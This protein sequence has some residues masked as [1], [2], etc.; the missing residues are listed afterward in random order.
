VSVSND[1][2]ATSLS[3]GIY[4]IIVTDVN[5]CVESSSITLSS[6]SLIY[7]NINID[8]V[9]CNGYSDGA[10]S[11][12]PS[13]GIPPYTFLWSG[14]TSPLTSSTISGLNAN[15][16]YYVSITDSN[17]CSISG[18]PVD[19]PEPPAMSVNFTAHD[20]NGYN[21]SCY[22][23][24]NAIVTSNINGGIPPYTYSEDNVS[25]SSDSIS[26]SNPSGWYIIYVKDANSC[27][28]TDSVNLTI[29]TPIYPNIS[30]FDSLTCNGSIDGSAVVNPSGGSGVYNIIWFE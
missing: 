8:T 17:G 7:P 2:I 5:G 27:I 30:I 22:D 1:S 21:I 13:G 23:S 10:A 3:L 18:V 14:T 6:P 16:T 24:S 20:Y 19:I 28:Q 15:V 29:A 11:V 12:N 4:N 9:T 26:Y 25:Y